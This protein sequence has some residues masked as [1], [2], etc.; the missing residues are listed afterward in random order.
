MTHPHVSACS[1]LAR[2]LV[3]ERAE[4]STDLAERLLD[5]AADGHQGAINALL[6]FR[7]CRNSTIDSLVATLSVKGPPLPCTPLELIDALERFV[8]NV[9]EQERSAARSEPPP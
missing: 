3:V 5:L 7:L 8:D 2:D 1:E 6:A 4:S 9:W